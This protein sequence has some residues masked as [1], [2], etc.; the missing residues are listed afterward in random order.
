MEGCSLFL[1]AATGR[2]AEFGANSTGSP[3]LHIMLAEY[4]Y[5]KSLEVDMVKVT[6]HFVRGNNPKKS[7]ATLVNF[8]GK[9]YPG[10]DDLAIARAILR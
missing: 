7:A 10:E 8:M 9:C 1:K 3:E 4:I 2:S 6:N 5:S